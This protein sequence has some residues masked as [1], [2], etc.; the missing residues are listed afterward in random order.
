MIVDTSAFIA[1][2][3]AQDDAAIYAHAIADASA[4]RLSA[5][6]YLECGIVSITSEIR[7]SAE[8]WTSYLRKRSS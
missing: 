5:A 8:A 7:S 3:T 1:I 2:L 6:S 4:R